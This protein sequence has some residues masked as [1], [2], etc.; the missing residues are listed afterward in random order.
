M[1][2]VVLIFVGTSHEQV[3]RPIPLTKCCE[4]DDEF[5]ALGFDSCKTEEAPV[6]WPPPVYSTRTN[7]TL[8]GIRPERFQVTRNLSDCPDGHVGISWTD[9]L[10]YDDGSLLAG[11]GE[12]FGRDEFCVNQVMAEKGDLGPVFAAR[13]CVADPC[14]GKPCLRKC[15]PQG[16]AVNNTDRLC[17]PTSTPFDVIYHN[18][19][20]GVVSPDPKIIIRDGVA[21]QC[22]YGFDALS[23]VN[24]DVFYIVADGR[25][26]IP[27]FP[28]GEQYTVEYC[29][30]HFVEDE[31]TVR[32]PSLIIADD[33]F[34]INWRHFYRSSRRS[35]VSR[36]NRQS[37]R[38]TL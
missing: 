8:V 16:M 18:E 10:I 28:E 11:D 19:S 3:I 17:H 34:K 6:S 13:T 24:G 5:Y 4:A 27:N 33:F 37:R 12:R 30:D 26:F 7:R 31:N 21:P 22:L 20:G 2:V 36:R 23:Q 25:L 9:F 1:A 32:H 15:C 35:P 29:L 14:D 38:P